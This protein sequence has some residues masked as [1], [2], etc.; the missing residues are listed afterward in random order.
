MADGLKIG[1]LE[2]FADFATSGLRFTVT[3]GG[4][5]SLPTFVGEDDEVVGASG[6]DPGEWI[7]D[8][9]EVAMH[10]FVVGT[11][12]DAQAIRESFRT[13][14]AALLAKMHVP[15]LVD[16]VAYPPFFGLGTGDTATLPDCRPLSIEG[17]DP[18]DL[19]FE[20]WEVTLRLLC[21][22]SPPDWVVDEGS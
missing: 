3:R 5:Q 20:G 22:G 6:R 18:V 8:T 1:G 16:I 15:T 10:G 19:W 12:D 14:S 9:R 13:R 11:G 2:V 17:P 7:A 4:L 21:I